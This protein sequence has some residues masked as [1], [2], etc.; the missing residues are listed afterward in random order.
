MCEADGQKARPSPRPQA[1]HALNAT[2][3]ETPTNRYDVLALDF[4]L[5]GYLGIRYAARGIRQHH[6]A[7]DGALR[8]GWFSRERHHTAQNRLSRHL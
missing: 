6:R 7:A 3:F 5:A 2:L 8:G 1:K 4:S